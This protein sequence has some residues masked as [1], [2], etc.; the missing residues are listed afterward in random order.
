MPVMLTHPNI[1]PVAIQLG[2]LAVHWYGIMYLLGF[3]GFWWFGV[4]RAQHP[5]FEW[6]R[7]RVSDLLFYGVLGVILGGRLG[8]T[9]FYNFDRFVADPLS[10]LRIWEG[11]MSFHGG[12]I[13][14]L[15]AVAW[16]PTCTSCASST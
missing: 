3:L 7:E 11:G 12:L 1:D 6:P 8:Y 14:V 4:K 10:I 13:G 5:Q 9:L 15:V 16:S 2:P